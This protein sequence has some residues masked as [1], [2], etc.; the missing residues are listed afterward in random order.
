MLFST[1]LGQE[2]R[3]MAELNYKRIEALPTD[4]KEGLGGGGGG[5]REKLFPQSCNRSD[6]ES[7]REKTRKC[8]LFYTNNPLGG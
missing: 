5:W 4:N 1:K 7:K 6:G 3:P 8:M 2:I